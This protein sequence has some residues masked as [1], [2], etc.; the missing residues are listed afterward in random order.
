MTRTSDRRERIGRPIHQI[1][2]LYVNKEMAAEKVAQTFNITVDQVYM[3]KHRVTELIKEEARRLEQEM[4]K[5][6]ADM[7]IEREALAQEEAKLRSDLVQVGEETPRE[8]MIR[9]TLELRKRRKDLEAA[10][11]I[12]ADEGK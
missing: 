8:K 4:A 1:F 5:V 11:S 10:R 12:P 6:R 2:D 7:K 3:A 9:L